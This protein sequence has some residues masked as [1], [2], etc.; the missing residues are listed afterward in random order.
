MKQTWKKLLSVVLCLFLAIGSLT[1]V[2]CG[3]NNENKEEPI[4]PNKT[5]LYIGNQNYGFGDK[6]LEAAE[7]K[8]EEMFKDY[9]FEPG[10]DKKGIQIYYDNGSGF[11]GTGLLS[12]LKSSSE[13]DI[14]F[15]EATNYYDYVLGDVMMDLTS[16]IDGTE[17][18]SDV[19]VEYGGA[20]Y[21]EAG[22]IE[23]K[24]LDGFRDFYK[25]P[26]GISGMPEGKYF[27]LPN[28]EC[29]Y[30]MNYNIDMW[31]KY[32]LFFDEDGEIGVKNTNRE[33]LSAGPDGVKGNYDDGLPATFDQF[34]EVCYEFSN[35]TNGGSLISWPGGIASYR[36]VYMQELFS[37]IEG[38]ESNLLG[39]FNGTATR[40]IKVQN[41]QGRTEMVFDSNGNPVLETKTIQPSN[42][43]EAY[44]QSGR[45]WAVNFFERIIEGGY[46]TGGSTGSDDHYTT[47][48]NFI[49]SNF[50]G[51]PIA[52]LYDGNFWQ[53]EADASF[54]TV[55]NKYGNK[56][57]KEVMNF[58]VL[59]V[60]RPTADAAYAGKNAYSTSGNSCSFIYKNVPQERLLAAKMFFQFLYTD[61]QLIEYNRIV[62]SARGCKVEMTKEELAT[63]TPYARNAYQ[64]RNESDVIV[65]GSGH[66]LY[67]NNMSTFTSYSHGFV[68]YPADSKQEDPIMYLRANIN[69]QTNAAKAYF[70]GLMNNPNYTSSGWNSMFGSQIG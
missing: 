58:G 18:Y 59:P 64:Y 4:D 52:I 56:A 2:A 50:Q 10:T 69:G 34:F 37:S 42:A 32:N 40:L 20:E 43:Y 63:L 47:Q 12:S 38:K 11:S 62:G 8:F 27:A 46:M 44:R 17:D 25:T 51:G 41:N 15:G 24:L 39:T 70:E 19:F 28:Y 7:I 14:Y 54:K 49:K 45:Y 33:L 23:D 3:D 31:N 48:M 68:S 57:S 60:P 30:Q 35:N 65:S 36:N 13:Y 26:T 1:L 67:V 55:V 53:N 66:P 29:T 21:T 6:W 22:S 5:Q 61:A 16:L 9:C